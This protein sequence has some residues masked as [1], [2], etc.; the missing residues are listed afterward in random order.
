MRTTVKLD[1]DIL[2]VAARQAKARGV[3]LGKMIS[4][5]VRKGLR[6]QTPVRVERGVTVFDLPEDSPEVTMDRVTELENERR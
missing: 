5:L 1:D 2:E 3:S 6:V 4:E